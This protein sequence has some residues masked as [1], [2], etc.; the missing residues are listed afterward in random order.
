V[1]LASACVRAFRL[2]RPRTQGKFDT[3]GG[4]IGLRPH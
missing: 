4:E 2:D 3:D 1:S